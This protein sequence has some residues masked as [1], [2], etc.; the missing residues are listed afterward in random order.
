MEIKIIRR[1]KFI[2]FYK[3]LPKIIQFNFK[4][5][6]NNTL[7]PLVFT[8]TTTRDCDIIAP[9][10]KESPQLAEQYRTQANYQALVHAYQVVSWRTHKLLIV[11]TLLSYW[12]EK[13]LGFMAATLLFQIVLLFNVIDDSSFG[14]GFLDTIVAI[15]HYFASLFSTSN[16]INHIASFL[17]I[18]TISLFGFFIKYKFVERSSFLDS[19]KGSCLAG[20]SKKQYKLIYKQLNFDQR[21]LATHFFVI[22]NPIHIFQQTRINWILI[23]KIKVNNHQRWIIIN[24]DYFEK[25]KQIFGELD[26]LKSNLQDNISIKRNI[27]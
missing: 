16:I 27:L 26:G 25:K 12:L 14:L 4:T 7:Y 17:N 22:M 24:T 18:V 3:F 6:K 2:I 21:K 9:M 23:N 5:S 1:N 13:L 10:E 8:S 11:I 20:V 15:Y 19:S